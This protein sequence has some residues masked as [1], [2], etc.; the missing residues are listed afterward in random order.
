M[1]GTII[2]F[3]CCLQLCVRVSPPTGLS[4]VITDLV[5]LIEKIFQVQFLKADVYPI[6]YLPSDVR[7]PDVA[8]VAGTALVMSTLAALYPAWRASKVQP[9]VA[10]RYD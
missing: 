9:A 3:G 6:S 10:L 1:S 2:I 7:W 8:R 4:L 5:A